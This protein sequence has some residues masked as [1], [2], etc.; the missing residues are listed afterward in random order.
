[1]TI[2]PVPLESITTFLGLSCRTVPRLIDTV[3]LS[4]TH[5]GLLSSFGALIVVV[6]HFPTVPT[7]LFG[8]VC[9]SLVSYFPLIVEF[10]TTFLTMSQ[11]LSTF[12]VGLLAHWLTRM[13]CFIVEICS[14]ASDSSAPGPAAPQ[15]FCMLLSQPQHIQHHLNF[16]PHLIYSLAKVTVI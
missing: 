15:V 11:S 9:W 6:S 3:L 4:L 8:S 7:H 2:N 13:L 1:M 10:C 5:C 16:L 12:N 14:I